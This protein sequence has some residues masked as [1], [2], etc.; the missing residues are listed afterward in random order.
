M[1]CWPLGLIWHLRLTLVAK[2]EAQNTRLDAPIDVQ[3]AQCKWTQWAI[4]I[5]L[6][7]IAIL[8]A[9]FGILSRTS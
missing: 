1:S 3:R 7:L 4:D 5:G 9:A 6:T 8:V 2:L